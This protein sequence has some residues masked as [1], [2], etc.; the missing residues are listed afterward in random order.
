MND[1]KKC[2]TTHS[3]DTWCPYFTENR[4]APAVALS[5]SLPTSEP[6]CNQVN[7]RL[8]LVHQCRLGL[9]KDKGRK[10]RERERRIPVRHATRTA[11]R[12]QSDKKVARHTYGR[13]CER[14]GRLLNITSSE[15]EEEEAAFRKGLLVR[16]GQ[17]SSSARLMRVMGPLKRQVVDSLLRAVDLRVDSRGCRISRYDNDVIEIISR[18]AWTSKR[19]NV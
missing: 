5:R 4:R 2:V 17:L 7:P 13:A 8:T 1:D 16:D 6:G 14:V 15:G 3:R 11:E 12:E 9:S 18:P 19:V 10:G